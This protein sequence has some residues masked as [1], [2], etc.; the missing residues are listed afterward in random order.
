MLAGRIGAPFDG[1]LVGI[2]A[3]TFEKKF[4]IL[5]PAKTAHGFNISSQTC[6]LL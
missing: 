4:K 5:A 3:L 1:A 6:F 2:T